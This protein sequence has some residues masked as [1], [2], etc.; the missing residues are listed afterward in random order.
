MRK[1]LILSSVIFMVSMVAIG[2]EQS[3]PEFSKATVPFS[4]IASNLEY[5]GIAVKEDDYTVWGAAPIMDDKGKVHLYV[6]RWPEKN[7]DP[8]WRKSSEIAHYVADH[9][10]GP[11]KFLSVVLKG[12]GIKGAWDRYAPS[13][14]DIQRIDGKYVLT[15]IGNSDYHQPP[16]PLNQ[17]IGMMIADSSYGPWKKVGNNG[18][19]L[20][21]SNDPEHFS[22]G[23]QVVNPTLAKFKG[24]YFLYYKTAMHTKRGWRTVFAAAMAD[25]LEGPYRHPDRPFSTEDVVIEDASVFIWND[26]L[27]LL[28]TDNHGL[29]TGIGG[30][31]VMWISEDGKTCDPALIQVGFD[32]LWRYYPNYDP[33]KTTK[34]YGPYPKIERPKVLMIKGKPAYLYGGSGWEITGRPRTVNYVFKI[35]LPAEAGPMPKAGPEAVGSLSRI[36]TEPVSET[37]QLNLDEPINRW[38]E[39]VP[40]GNGLIGGLL[41]GDKNEIRLSLDRGDLWDVRPHPSYIKPGFNYDKVKE[42]AL[43][44][45]T[46]QLNKKYSRAN[47][48]PTKLPGGRLVLTL[49]PEQKA[50]SFHLDMRNAK[51]RVDLG[52]ASLECFFSATKPVA[53]LKIPGERPQFKLVANEAVKKLG[54]KPAQAGSDNDSVW[55]VQDAA[56]GFQ[57]AVYVQAAEIPDGT[58][59]AVTM[60]TNKESKAPLTLARKQ[61]RQALDVGFAKLFAEHKKWWADFWGKSSVSVPHE[62]IQHHY[63]LVQYFYGAASRRGA[64]P[65][66]LQGLWTADAGRLP[67]W[68]GD[69]HNDLNTQLTYWAYYASGRFE[70]GLSFLDFMWDLKPVHEKWTKDFWGTDGFVVPG[71]MSLDGKPMGSW[72]QYTLSPTMGAWVAQAF[73][74]HWLYTMDE[75]FLRDR[76]YPYCKGIAEALVDLMDPDENGRLK[77]PLSTSPELHNNRQEAWVTPNSNF[78][79]SL[80]RWIFGANAEMAGALGKKDEAAHWETLL[81]KMDDLAVE[82]RD[83]ALRVSPDES[84]ESSHRHFSHLMA[85]HP[86]GIVNVEGGERDVNIIKASLDQMEQLGTKAWCGYSFSWMACMQARVGHA[87][88]ALQYLDD[89]VNS[90][91]LRNGFHCNGEQTR[92]GLSNFHYR[93]FTLEGNFA[94]G[95]AVHEMLLQS[96]GGKVR[97]FPAVPEAWADVSFENLRSEGGFI[98]SAARSKGKTTHVT[99]TA[100]VDN[101][102]NLYHSFAGDSFESNVSVERSGD[103]LTCEMKKGQVLKLSVSAEVAATTDIPKPT[104]AQLTW[105][106]SEIGLLYCFDLPIAAKIY[107][108][109]NTHRQR[110]DPAEYKPTH[111]DT[112]KW[113]AVAKAANAK[114]ALF[115]ATHFSGFMQWQSDVYPYG[116]KQSPWRD[117]KGDV[118]GDF[119]TSCRKAGVLPGIFFSTHRNVYQEV[120]GHYVKWGKGNGTPEQEAYNRIAERQFTELMTRYGDIFH[121]WFDAGNKTLE[122]GGGNLLPI[123][124]KHQP[125]GIFYHSTKRSDVRWVGNEDGYANAPCYATMPSNGKGGFTL[126]DKKRLGKDEPDDSV[127]VWTTT[128]RKRLGKGDPDGSV[129][130]PAIVDIPLRGNRGHNWFY[131]PG[132]DKIVYPADILMEKYYTSVGRNANLI[133]G[134]VIKPDGTIPEADVKVLTEFG[135]KLRERF[136]SPV[137]VIKGVEGD[138]IE[139]DLPEPWEIDHVILQ[140]DIAHGERVRDHVVEGRIGDEW[141]TLAEGKVIGHKWIYRFKPQTVSRLRLR[142][143]KSVAGPRIRSFACY[144]VGGQD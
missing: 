13:N 81:G 14:P 115:T 9:P 4:A 3:F 68:H 82:G 21:D 59:L 70:Q 61:A 124:E 117:G 39:A 60:T 96:W 12:S 79:L 17:Q 66:P 52:D 118:V 23:H 16:H 123:F 139:L 56:L 101:T 99:I 131:E 85:I 71:V 88:R 108:P 138:V 126:K 90:F 120:W 26:K 94:A 10:E 42:L 7:V 72:F 143:T 114:Y 44:G 121:I 65:M 98:V 119:V 76:A 53:L 104:P 109:N 40:L 64:P 103:N 33:K 133:I 95:Q 110:V 137:A 1:S 31:G 38:D 89:Y 57:Y 125:N 5:K 112:D 84:L 51:G 20:D 132:Q 75:Q 48:F 27:C 91:I 97:I 36:D 86:L 37:F 135:R 15:Y 80:L 141:V 106:D 136:A 83:G 128:I 129:W 113:L 130:S 105:Q 43:V 63:N 55:F 35:N 29:V 134:V 93:P 144:M 67:P 50:Q 22:H 41:W 11:F 30:G 77:L 28:T 78:D 100:T 25:K 73:H 19:I 2:A 34:V 45:K 111:L 127:F 69:Y 142:V 122:E 58:L 107:K 62:K 6:A 46:D 87:D 47:D 54:N 140:E 18:L 92:K 8:A 49:A 24:K 116:L 32:N 74:W 102:L